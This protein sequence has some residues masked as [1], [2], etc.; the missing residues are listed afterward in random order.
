[1]KKMR[2]RFRQ[3]RSLFDLL[4]EY[5]QPLALQIVR[6]THT[7]VSFNEATRIS[8]TDNQI[9]DL[10]ALQLLVCWQFADTRFNSTSTSSA[11]KH[12]DTISLAYIT[13]VHIIFVRFEHHCSS[14][15]SCPYSWC[16]GLRLGLAYARFAWSGRLSETAE[17]FICT[18]IVS[19]SNPTPA[20]KFSTF[21][22][23]T[24]RNLVIIK[25]RFR[26]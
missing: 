19:D 1:M 23:I 16:L 8:F 18:G 25:K 22:G 21:G 3:N 6:C 10:L 9:S 14:W 11:P 7:R 12:I 24:L 26:I 17:P 13:V 15:F 5:R 2:V 20:L 4:L